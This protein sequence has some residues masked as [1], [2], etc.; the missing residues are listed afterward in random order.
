MM[1]RA[2]GCELP[3]DV[4]VWSD[5]SGSWGCGGIWDEKWFQVSWEECPQFSSAPIAAKELLPIL[6]ASAIWGMQ[7]KG[8]RVRCH[9]DNQAVVAVIRGGYCREPGIDGSFIEVL[10]LFGGEV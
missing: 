4:E 2:G 10:V 5:A 8:L 9:C 3:G 6:V 1:M 7:W